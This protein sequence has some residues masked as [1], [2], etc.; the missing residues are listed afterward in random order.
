MPR[1]IA[2]ELG[3]VIIVCPEEAFAFA[4][5]SVLHV[6]SGSPESSRRI[7]CTSSPLPLCLCFF[8]SAS[9]SLPL[10][11]CSVRTLLVINF[12]STPAVPQPC[13]HATQSLMGLAGTLLQLR[14]GEVH[15]QHNRRLRSEV[16][17]DRL[18]ESWALE[19]RGEWEAGPL[20]HGA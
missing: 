17:H 11:P 10:C 19:H 2:L 1:A 16:G 4:F 12:F 14:R 18:R 8:S 5:P 6:Y 7:A 13:R 15:W 9:V 3:K 20:A